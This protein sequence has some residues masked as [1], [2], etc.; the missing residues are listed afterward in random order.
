MGVSLGLWLLLRAVVP[1]V[2]TAPF[3]PAFYGVCL[4]VTKSGVLASLGPRRGH[5]RGTCVCLNGCPAWYICYLDRHTL[6]IHC[7]D[8]FWGAMQVR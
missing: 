6:W 8:R 4:V 7:G 3:M 5:S 2:L 1:E